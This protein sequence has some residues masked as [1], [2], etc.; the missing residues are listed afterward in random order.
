M[1][2]QVVLGVIFAASASAFAPGASLPRVMTLRKSSA[3]SPQMRDCIFDSEPC[4]SSGE[5]RVNN[6]SERHRRTRSTLSCA[7]GLARGL[8]SSLCFLLFPLRSR[9]EEPLHLT[10]TLMSGAAFCD[11]NH[12]FHQSG[13]KQSC[14]RRAAPQ[15]QKEPTLKNVLPEVQK[16]LDEVRSEQGKK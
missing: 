10:D 3:I 1:L 16:I 12:G 4:E 11:D 9:K 8:F 14:A 5:C 15:P 6:V 7:R 2:K 13:P